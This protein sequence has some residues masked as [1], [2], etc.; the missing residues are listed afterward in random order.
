MTIMTTL[1]WMEV[2]PGGCLIVLVESSVGECAHLVFFI[3]FL[4]LYMLPAGQAT[5]LVNLA[6]ILEGSIPCP[7]YWMVH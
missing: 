4:P 3:G 2:R 5:I 1:R 6:T 7:P